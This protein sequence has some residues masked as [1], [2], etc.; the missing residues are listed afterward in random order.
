MARIGITQ[1]E[2]FQAAEAIRGEGETPS[3][4][5][6]R[7]AEHDPQISEN[8]ESQFA[9]SA[10]GSGGAGARIVGGHCRQHC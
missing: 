1:E 8:L 2:V 7:V 4:D 6:V 3:I 10:S 9:A 5:R